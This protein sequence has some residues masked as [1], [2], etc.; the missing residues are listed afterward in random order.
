MFIKDAVDGVGE[1]KALL[2][3][4]AALQTD[5][6]ELAALNISDSIEKHNSIYEKLRS[7]QKKTSKLELK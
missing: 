4:L 2:D 6:E 5:R 1:E 3:D 7:L